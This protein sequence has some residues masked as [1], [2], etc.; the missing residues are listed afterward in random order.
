[1]PAEPVV[2]TAIT[3]RLCVAKNEQGWTG[4]WTARQSSSHFAMIGKLTSTLHEFD[5]RDTAG[6]PK[7]IA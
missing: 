4:Q 7:G 5:G 6:T 3:G 1:M 2:C